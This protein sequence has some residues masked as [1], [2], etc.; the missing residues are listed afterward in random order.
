MKTDATSF[1][2][3]RGMSETRGIEDLT[4]EIW[5]TRVLVFSLAMESRILK[6]G[7]SWHSV[8]VIV[9]RF[10]SEPAIFS[11]TAIHSVWGTRFSM[12]Y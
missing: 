11:L 7:C 8:A 1:R 3:R 12:L 10:G 5:P 2:S 6:H 9:L 4:A